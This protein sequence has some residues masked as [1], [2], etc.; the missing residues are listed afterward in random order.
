[1]IV[2]NLPNLRKGLFPV[3]DSKLMKAVPD[4]TYDLCQAVLDK[5]VGVLP[6]TNSTL[7]SVGSG[8]KF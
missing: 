4:F 2:D 6:S 8:F 1:M 3:I 5:Y 7:F